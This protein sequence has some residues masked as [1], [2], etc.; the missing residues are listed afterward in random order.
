MNAVAR[1]WYDHPD[2]SR[3]EIVELLGD[4]TWQGFPPLG[5]EAKETRG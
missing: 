4:V 1:W 3:Q 2:V 5:V